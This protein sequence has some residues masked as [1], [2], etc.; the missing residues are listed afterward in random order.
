M[1]VAGCD[2]TWGW[3][4]QSAHTG[5]E[6][7][8]SASHTWVGEPRSCWVVSIRVDDTSE[9]EIINHGGTDVH[10]GEVNVNTS[11]QEPTE[12]CT[13]FH[14]TYSYWGVAIGR[15]MQYIPI[16]GV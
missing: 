7:V 1:M 9:V 6:A 15:W 16:E 5:F 12:T 8:V 3:R 13:F 2:Y 10:I 14:G 4:R 11:G